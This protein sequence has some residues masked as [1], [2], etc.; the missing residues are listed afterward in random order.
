MCMYLELHMSINICLSVVWLLQ[1]SFCV[2]SDK[3]AVCEMCEGIIIFMKL[4]PCFN[5]VIK[6]SGCIF[7]SAMRIEQVLRHNT[8]LRYSEITS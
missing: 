6:K 5:V 2:V 8:L 7:Y 1:Y 3:M 4:Q